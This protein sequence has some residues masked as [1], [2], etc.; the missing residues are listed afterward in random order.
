MLVGFRS[1]NASPQRGGTE[2]QGH[3]LLCKLLQNPDIILKREPYAPFLIPTHFVI[4]SLL[5]PRATRFEKPANQELLGGN[6]DDKHAMA[7][8]GSSVV[9]D[10]L[11]QSSEKSSKLFRKRRVAAEDSL[12]R[13]GGFPKIRGTLLGVP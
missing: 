12:V 6:P 2:S 3:E 8:A 9:P 5:S 7:L 10:L 13:T 11:L 1:V 4:M